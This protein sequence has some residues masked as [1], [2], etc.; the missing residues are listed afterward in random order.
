VIDVRNHYEAAIGRF[1]RQESNS[2]DDI[3]GAEYVDP[4]M[5][6]STDFPDW[7]AKEE[8]RNKL[9]GKQ[10]LMVSRRSSKIN[11][12]FQINFGFDHPLKVLY[13]RCAM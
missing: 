7:L 5:R 12:F 9:E 10:V 2:K 8:T 6:R 1:D 4:M 3:K 11:A 13:R